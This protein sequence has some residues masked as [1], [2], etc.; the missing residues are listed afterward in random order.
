VDEDVHRPALVCGYC[1]STYFW[2]QH[3]WDRNRLL[4][5]GP[6]SRRPGRYL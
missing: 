4:P 2:R 6:C 5:P 3:H 1:R